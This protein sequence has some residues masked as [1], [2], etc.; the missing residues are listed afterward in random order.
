MFASITPNAAPRDCETPHGNADGTRPYGFKPVFRINEFEHAFGVGHTKTY[1]LI[2]AGEIEAVKIGSATGV[3]GERFRVAGPTAADP[4][5]G[6][7]T[8]LQP[9]KRRCPQPEGVGGGKA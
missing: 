5:Q 8:C 3:T 4:A 9:Q 2:N 6:R 1:Q 7:L